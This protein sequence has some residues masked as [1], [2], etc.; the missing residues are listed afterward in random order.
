MTISANALG[1][2][3]TGLGKGG[4]FAAIRRHGYAVI[5]L[6]ARQAA[7]QSR[8]C[9]SAAEFFALDTAA[10]M[11]YATDA[12]NA[13]YR[14][15]RSAYARS[16][17]YPDVNESFLY[18]T[19]TP[20]RIPRGREAAAFLDCLA[21]Y[22]AMVAAV[23]AE[24]MAEICRHYGHG[25]EL[26]FAE[27]SFVQVNS[28]PE[29]RERE[30]LQETHEDAVFLSTIWASADGLELMLDGEAVPAAFAGDDLLVM[31]GSIMTDMTGGEIPPLYHR[32]RNHGHEGR[33][34]VVYFVNPEVDR[35]VR[36]FVSAPDGR[37]VDIR[38]RV[39]RNPQEFFGLSADFM[40]H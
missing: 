32:V 17:E 25:G 11:R 21:D 23:V 22:R 18:W 1:G 33:K 7:V 38:Q 12:R 2:T 36:P 16:P 4:V 3:G 31:P 6:G 35:P 24:I 27:A 37:D 39:L 34:S 40:D 20:R 29:D 14:P 26:P 9:A 10:K 15:V 28:Y 19:T 30:F 13:G 8:L 5:R